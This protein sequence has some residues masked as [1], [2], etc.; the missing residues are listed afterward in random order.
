MIFDGTDL[1]TLGL[2]VLKSP[3][4]LL[5]V[6]RLNIEGFGGADGAG[7]QGAFYDPREF[8]YRVLIEGAGANYTA[9]RL[10]LVEQ[11][12]ALKTILNPKLGNR[13]LQPI[14]EGA[15]DVEVNRGYMVRTSGLSDGQYLNP[16][17]IECQLQ[18]VAPIPFGLELNA[19]ETAVNWNNVSATISTDPQDITVPASGVV[20]GTH[21]SPP[22][23]R[24]KNTDSGAITSLTITNTT[25]NEG[26]TWTGSLAQNE[27]LRFN[28]ENQ[29]ILRL[30]A[31][32]TD[33]ET[34]GANAMIG[35]ITGDPFP[36]L[37]P[38]VANTIRVQGVVAATFDIDWVGRFL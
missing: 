16:W 12:D 27:Q 11:L 25:R 5:P 36:F 1:T 7:T 21:Q 10:A 9:K 31:G 18:F 35:V 20:L 37:E 38:G 24:I 15:L 17:T 4:T 13:L 3:Q 32:E 19:G 34:Q 23:F 26:I 22:I 30:D 33:W 28:T 6:F 2:T 14:M 8:D 29:H